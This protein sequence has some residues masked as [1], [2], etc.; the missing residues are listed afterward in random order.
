M[1]LGRSNATRADVQ[2]NRHA[3]RRGWREQVNRE[4]AQDAA[5]EQRRTAAAA[6]RQAPQRVEST[7]GDQ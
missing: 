6:A 5:A 7:R 3:E 1:A 2:G 4:R